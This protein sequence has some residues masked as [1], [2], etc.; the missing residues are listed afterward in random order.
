M[1]AKKILTYPHTAWRRMTSAVRRYLDS[2]TPFERLL[3][4]GL[5]TLAIIALEVIQLTRAA[6]RAEHRGPEIEQP[7]IL[8]SDGCG[9]EQ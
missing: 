9:K 1:N 8:P 3:I 7:H 2:R 5:L 4:V 6:Y